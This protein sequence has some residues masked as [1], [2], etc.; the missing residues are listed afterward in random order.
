MNR[1]KHQT[2]NDTDID[3]IPNVIDVSI[4]ENMNIRR[5]NGNNGRFIDDFV[6]F[7]KHVTLEFQN[8]NQKTTNLN[9]KDQYPQA[10]NWNEKQG[11]WT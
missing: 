10:N 9:M 5:N 11:E 6:D 1:L 2:N 7:K 8:I 3:G 4:D